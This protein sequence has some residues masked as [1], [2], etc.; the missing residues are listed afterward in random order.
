L[1]LTSFFAAGFEF[2]TFSGGAL[3]VVDGLVGLPDGMGDLAL[4]FAV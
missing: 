3:E 2:K 4:G 1:E